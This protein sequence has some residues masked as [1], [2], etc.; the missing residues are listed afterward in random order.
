MQDYVNS[1]FVE[2]SFLVFKLMRNRGVP[3]DG[4]TFPILIKIVLSLD[5]SG[6]WFTEMIHCMGKRME[7]ESDVYFA[8]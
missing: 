3:C 1:E 7:F 6:A 5:K 2:S 4:F 8:I